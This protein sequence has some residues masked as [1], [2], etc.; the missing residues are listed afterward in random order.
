MK[1]YFLLAALML[2]LCGCESWYNKR[3]LTWTVRPWDASYYSYM[4]LS[5]AVKS[6]RTSLDSCREQCV[7]VINGE[8]TN[9][10]VKQASV[11]LLQRISYLNLLLEYSGLYNLESIEMCSAKINENSYCNEF[12]VEFDDDYSKGFVQQL[13][14]SPNQHLAE[15]LAIIT[16]DTI[17]S[18]NLQMNLK[19]FIQNMPKTPEFEFL[20]NVLIETE[21]LDITMENFAETADGNWGILIN[22]KADDQNGT[23]FEFLVTLPDSKNTVFTEC[24]ARA[25]NNKVG[26]LEDDN[27]LV[28]DDTEEGIAPVIIRRD[29]YVFIYSSKDA[30]ENIV[31]QVRTGEYADKIQKL[32]T[33][34]KVHGSGFIYFDRD[35]VEIIGEMMPSGILNYDKNIESLIILRNQDDSL[36]LTQYANVDFTKLFSIVMI[37]KVSESLENWLNPVIADIAEKENIDNANKQC[38]EALK[39]IYEDKLLPY[40]M[41]NQNKFPSAEEVQEFVDSEEYFYLNN[42]TKQDKSNLPLIFDRQNNHGSQVNVLFA[43]GTVKTFEI[44]HASPK[45]VISY[46]HSVYNYPAQIFADLLKQVQ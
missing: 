34:K 13:F 38:L 43:D 20:N 15:E 42:I 2:V 35:F 8:N 45:K 32:G 6:F 23:K 5:G 7:T 39:N 1:K 18:C 12:L 27:T 9:A 25:I 26:K 16:D 29:G 28:F 21:M 11:L 37:Q 3:N 33:P 31:K 14:D 36:L 19:N 24:C 44:E 17:F 4:E 22:H 46:L 40:A 41:K 10:T 30:I